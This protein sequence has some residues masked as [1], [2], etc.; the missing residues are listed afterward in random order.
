M[1]R[2]LRPKQKA[3][4]NGHLS[5]LPSVQEVLFEF[6]GQPLP[7]IWWSE[8]SNPTS[9]RQNARQHNGDLV[10]VLKLACDHIRAL[11]AKVG[12][13]AGSAGERAA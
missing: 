4:P 10:K 11:E 1:L 2:Q 8:N 13:L 3:T 5:N 12:E 7:T 9:R 6:A